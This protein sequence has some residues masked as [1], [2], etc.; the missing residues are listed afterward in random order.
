MQRDLTLE[1]L[2][3]PVVTGLGYMFIG[4]QNIPQ[5]K[6]SLLRVY[7]DKQNG[8]TVDDCEKV[9]RQVGAMLE[10]EALET[11]NYTLEISSPGLDRLL[12][13]LE[14]FEGQ[15]GNQVSIQLVAPI[16]GRRNYKGML[17]S[18]QKGEICIVAEQ[19]TVTLSFSDII[20]ARLVPDWKAIK[21]NG[22]E[23]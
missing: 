5:G 18:V 19:K 4:L 9:S 15:I 8:V 17:T 10:V 1:K 2:V 16:E 23:A 14:Q 11:S 6:H 21:S 13:N 7:I 3:A 22:D 12:F 20:E